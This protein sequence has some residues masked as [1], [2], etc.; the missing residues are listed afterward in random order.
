MCSFEKI[1]D[2]AQIKGEWH[3]V[4]AQNLT[5]E[6]CKMLSKYRLM[7]GWLD[8]HIAAQYGRFDSPPRALA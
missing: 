7:R 5:L 8:R 1:L 3:C 6:S 4:V 2:T